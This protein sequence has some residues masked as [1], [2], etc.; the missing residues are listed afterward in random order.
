MISDVQEGGWG[1]KY[2]LAV[3]DV[4]LQVNG[5]VVSSLE[6]FTRLYNEAAKLNKPVLFFIYKNGG[7]A[8][9][10]IDKKPN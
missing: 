3:G 2:G 8:F 10:A 4:I 6:D 5:K 1:E 7:R 9:I